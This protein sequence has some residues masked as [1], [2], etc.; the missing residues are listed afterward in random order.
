V[1]GF[2]NYVERQ[3]RCRAIR[4][5]ELD[6]VSELVRYLNPA[7]YTVG[8]D[9]KVVVVCRPDNDAEETVV[10]NRGDYLIQGQ[11]Y[12]YG[13]SGYRVMDRHEFRLKY[14]DADAAAKFLED[15]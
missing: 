2:K 4:Y 7:S 15:A 11:D 12:G 3:D 5:M 10:I 14:E 9:W 13:H 1:T 6:Q 8:E